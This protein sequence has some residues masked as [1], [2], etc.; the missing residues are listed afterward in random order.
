MALGVAMLTLAATAGRG[1]RPALMPWPFSIEMGAGELAVGPGFRVAVG[2]EGGPLVERAAK[3]FEARLARQTGLVLPSPVAMAEKPTLAIR[4]D[5]PGK[6]L[7]HL[8]MDESYALSVTPTG[9][10]LQAAEP[11]GILRG[12]ETFLQ[13]VA[14]GSR[15]RF[16]LP[17]S[18]SRTG[19]ASRGGDSCSTA[20]ATS[21]RSTR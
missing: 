4:C 6:P 2:G 16:A 10:T 21:C 9:A 5:S 15:P 8:G 7:P 3:R 19:P 18:S 1:T 14:P 20:R 17:R 12:L 11:W 13:L